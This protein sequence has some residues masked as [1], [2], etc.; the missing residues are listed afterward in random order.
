MRKQ[1]LVSSVRV[2]AL[3]GTALTSFPAI[4]STFVYAPG[5]L[6]TSPIILTENGNFVVFDAADVAQ[7]SGAISEAGGA[8]NIF[9]LGDGTLHLTG[10]NSYSG[11]TFVVQGTLRIG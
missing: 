1:V 9:K 6:R 2:A 10:A 5:E 8:Q 3:M 7:Q 4:A 11:L